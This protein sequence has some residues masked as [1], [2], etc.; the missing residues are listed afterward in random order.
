MAS[1]RG[2]QPRRLTSGREAAKSGVSRAGQDLATPS[3]EMPSLMMV[4][5][6]PP[7]RR[8]R[9]RDSQAEVET[10]IFVRRTPSAWP[11]V[12]L[13]P[14]RAGDPPLPWTASARSTYETLDAPPTT[15]TND[16]L[17]ATVARP[18]RRARKSSMPVV[19][20]LAAFSLAYAI[21]HDREVRSELVSE[22][23]ITKARVLTALETSAMELGRRVAEPR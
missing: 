12:F 16:R 14:R 15:T 10:R 17:E 2:L 5:A 9:I 1:A 22:L 21:G 7:P 11:N 18:K 6:S 4:Y 19:L 13:Q 3:T 20:F 8:A 23:R